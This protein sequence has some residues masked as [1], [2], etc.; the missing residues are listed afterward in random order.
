MHP[1]VKLGL[2]GES[3]SAAEIQHA[4][5]L[6]HD[7]ALELMRVSTRG[8]ARELHVRALRL[9]HQVATWTTHVPGAIVEATINELL[10]LH[11]EARELR[12]DKATAFGAP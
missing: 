1:I 10:A 11:R 2:A 6:L 12:A 8:S 3:S 4:E 9:K 5:A 7:I